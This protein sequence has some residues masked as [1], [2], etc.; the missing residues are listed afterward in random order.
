M[1]IETSP[2]LPTFAESISGADAKKRQRLVSVSA[3]CPHVDPMQAFLHGMGRE[4]FYWQE[5]GNGVIHVGFGAAADLR[6]WGPTRFQSIARQAQTLF[7]QA[8]LPTS[9]PSFAQAHLFGGFAFS[10]DFTPDNTW[11]VYHPA[12]FILPHYQLS[13][14][15]G[16]SE[17]RQA[18][19]TINALLDY[20]AATPAKRA[21]AEAVELA[22]ALRGA[23]TEQIEQ[24]QQT[25]IGMA[26]LP[27]LH[28]RCYPMPYATW[29]QILNAAMDQFR[30]GAL[31]KV[32]LSRVCELRFDQ[33]IDVATALAYLN[34]IYPDCYRFVFEPLPN[35]AF[36]GASPELLVNLSGQ[37]IRT[38][39]LA[40]SEPRGA[41]P[42]A[43]AALGRQLM[44]SVKDRHEH[45]L[46]VDV[47]RQRLQ[48][49]CD[50]L[51]VAAQPQLL[52][53][54]NIQ[55]LY[56]PVC[57]TLSKPQD[58]L[59]LLDVLHPT[60]AL[61]GVPRAQALDFI[62]QMEPVPRGW[63]AAPVGVINRHMEGTFTV[64]IR[65]AV[66]EYER[67]WLH[68]GAGIVEA[69]NPQKEWDETALKFRPILNALGAAA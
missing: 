15:Q 61:G 67:V 58:V 40:G 45:Q 68:A 46:V 12:Q 60:P 14:Q 6:A 64:A 3:P 47:L 11:S 35:H 17:E 39:G 51:D 28:S 59:S 43:D 25:P 49:L 33:K 1:K 22:T 52:K 34:R 4:R 54:S 5:P 57:G 20:P 8:Y 7:D 66:T 21:D 13:L 37:Q 19:L 23:L 38:M 32:V 29:E 48:P 16:S 65:S 50:K 63:Y 44:E 31:S 24:L 36:F 42:A 69:S 10:D 9:A 18:W 30:I 55:H 53:L 62:R 41:T 26:P 2:Q 56:T 27:Q